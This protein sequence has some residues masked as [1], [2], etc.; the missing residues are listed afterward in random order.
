[1]KTSA[2]RLVH[3][4]TPYGRLARWSLVAF[5][6]SLQSLVTPLCEAVETIWNAETGNSLWDANEGPVGGPYA[7]NWTAGIPGAGDAARFLDSALINPVHTVD[8]NGNRS[9]Q[10]ITFEGPNQAITLG[11]N[12]GG[13][14]LTI[15]NGN[16]D[17]FFYA[18][19]S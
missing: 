3:P 14:T 10:G 8:L 16:P 13:N 17:Q 15:G 2:R 4:T 7:D 5:L 1:M 9:V 12:V 6:A 11:T 18:I 19:Y